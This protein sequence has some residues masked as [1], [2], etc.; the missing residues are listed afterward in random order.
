MS[1]LQAATIERP[2][3]KQPLACFEIRGRH[4]C[5]VVAQAVANRI[6]G[7]GRLER[8]RDARENL[9]L[10]LRGDREPVMRAVV[11]EARDRVAE[12]VD[13]LAG[14][15]GRRIEHQ[16]VFQASLKREFARL[17]V[18]QMM[19]VRHFAAVLIHRRMAHRVAHQAETARKSKSMC[20]KC[21]DVSWSES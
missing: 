20:E 17:Q 14:G 6:P 4:R 9:D 3:A 19:R 12:G 2:G 7:L 5:S 1:P 18:Q 10:H 11:F 21:C 16:R 13:V 15:A 8:L